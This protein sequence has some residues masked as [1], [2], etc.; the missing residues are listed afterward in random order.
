MGNEA[1][2]KLVETETSKTITRLE[3]SQLAALRAIRL[4][5]LALES[6]INDLLTVGPPCGSHPDEIEAAKA[7]TWEPVNSALRH[8]GSITRMLREETGC[9]PVENLEELVVSL[10]TTIATLEGQQSERLSA[11]RLAKLHEQLARAGAPRRD[12]G[13]THRRYAGF[14]A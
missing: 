5:A 11:E 12:S 9:P 3:T 7:R 13:P 10:N 4:A 2:A 14:E 8:L 1:V 6:G